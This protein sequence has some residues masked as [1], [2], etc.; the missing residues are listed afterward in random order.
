MPHSLRAIAYALGGEVSGGQVLAPG[1]GHRPRDRSM[2]VRLSSA[3]PDGFV[4]NSFAGNDWR[5]CRDHVRAKLGIAREICSVANRPERPE[6]NL[7][8]EAAKARR[9]WRKRQPVE[10]SVAER[11]LRQARAYRGP[12]PATLGFLAA[13][14]DYPPTLI[15][16]FGMASEPEPGVVAIADAAVRGVHVTRLLPDGSDRIS[17]ATIGRG[18]VGTPI[19]LFPPNDLLGL[20]IVEGIEDGLS[21]HAAAGLGVWVAGT[22]GRMPA[23]ADAIPDYADCV[24]VF[25]HDDPAGRKGAG[26][27]TMRLRAR[28]VEALLKFLSEAAHGQS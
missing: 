20:A 8:E 23:L 17:K 12:I 16:A 27:L 4:I 25:G 2:S 7:A 13:S 11:Y 26:D 1:P 18:T 3:A 21:I 15:A 24:T 9:L 28:G 6:I 5:T 19:A 14:D 10:V 22:A